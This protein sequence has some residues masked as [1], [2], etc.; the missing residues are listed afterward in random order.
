MMTAP[1]ALAARLRA[2]SRLLLV[3]PLFGA[4]VLIV[5]GL[6]TASA[7]L[8][9][10]GTPS[11]VPTRTATATAGPVIATTMPARPTQQSTATAPAAQKPTSAQ[12][13]AAAQKPAA[14]RQPSPAQQPVNTAPSRVALPNTGTGGLAGPASTEQGA[15]Q[16]LAIVGA[17]IVLAAGGWCAARGAS[18][19]KH[20]RTDA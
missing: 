6:T 17:A 13:P 15:A 11:P 7:Q 19:R 1:A 2:R 18:S 14:A 8:G 20:D 5:G 16:L 12:Q 9:P 3:L 4:L 10:P